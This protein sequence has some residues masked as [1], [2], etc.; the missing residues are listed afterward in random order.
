[1][2]IIGWRS[3]MCR[4]AAES[5]EFSSVKKIFTFDMPWEWSLRKLL[6]PL[7]L[8]RY[9]RRFSAAF[10]PGERSAAYARWL[11]F[12]PSQI[13]KGLISLDLQPYAA[14][15]TQRRTSESY[16]RHFLYVGRYVREKR[17]DVLVEAYERYRS[18]VN[19]PWGLICCGI[20]PDAG[21]L[22]GRTGLSNQGFVQ[23]KDL[24][25]LYAQAGAFVIASD[26]EPWGMVIAEAAA[27][28][29]PIIC[30]GACGAHLELVKTGINGIVCETGSVESLASAMRWMHD[31][32][33]SLARMGEQASE[34]V[35][36]FSAT[37][38]AA[39]LL[40]RA[41]AVLGR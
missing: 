32:E 34:A 4:Y 23:P 5:K 30:T 3:K 14:A 7:Y 39:S 31:N 17:I 29:L 10:V 11:G 15:A 6:A 21:L 25:A 2:V 1:M 35:L 19:D 26:Y 18:R 13:D 9:L 8:W 36:A 22:F 27:S 28:G 16:P 20:G 33:S 41:N 38:W 12:R 24:P 40:A 37:V